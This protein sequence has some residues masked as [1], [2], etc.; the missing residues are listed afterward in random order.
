MLFI[1][2]EV[3]VRPVPFLLDPITWSEN[4]RLTQYRV[5][6]ARYRQMAD[7]EERAFVRNGLL[8][9]AQQCEA[10][11]DSI[12]QQAVKLMDSGA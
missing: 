7:A 12:I 11:A 8:A 6:A 1:S 3:S 9:L 4:E 2:G 5:L 10:A